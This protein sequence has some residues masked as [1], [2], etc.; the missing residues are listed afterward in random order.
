MR[1]RVKQKKLSRP[2]G[3]RKALRKSLLK[4]LI[5]SEQIKTTTPKAK[6]L[7]VHFDKIIT[8]AKKDS[9]AARRQAFD[10]IGDHS[11]VKKLFDEIG[12]RFKDSKGSCCR[13]YKIGFRN[14]DGAEMSIISLTKKSV[15]KE[16]L[17]PKAKGDKRLAEKVSPE[18][19]KKDSAGKKEVSGLKKMFKKKKRY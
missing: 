14:S 12:P 13:I 3:Q 1:H 6:L 7:K 5:I 2:L 4:A 8:L 19:T 15:L 9:L 10:R 18:T 17:K 16:K 11:L